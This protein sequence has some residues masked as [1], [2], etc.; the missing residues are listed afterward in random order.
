MNFPMAIKSQGVDK[1]SQR[2]ELVPG[3]VEIIERWF[4][5]KPT[6]L[7]IENKWRYNNPDRLIQS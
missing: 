4:S 1:I 7:T 3:G 6:E 2:S 5:S